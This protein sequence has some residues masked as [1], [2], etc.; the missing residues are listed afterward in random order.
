MHQMGYLFNLDEVEVRIFSNLL[1]DSLS[2]SAYLLV[3]P[4]KQEEKI[5][6]R[7][8]FTY[9]RETLQSDLIERIMC[10]Y[11]CDL[12]LLWESG[13]GGCC[14]NFVKDWDHP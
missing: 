12:I 4:H 6:S 1:A 10:L 13:G 11:I 9:F 8:L 5:K 2:Q 7:G 14:G 3:S